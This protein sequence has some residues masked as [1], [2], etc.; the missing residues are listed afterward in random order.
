M[1]PFSR[2]SAA[3]LRSQPS[4]AAKVLED[5]SADSVARYLAA[6]SP[7]TAGQVI[8]HFTPAFAAHCLGALEPVVAGRIFSLLLTDRQ[9]I[10]L[11][12]LEHDRRESLLQT[13]Q[14]DL[15]ASMR[16]L[17]PYP[18]GTAGAVMEAPLA[19]LPEELSVRNA[20]KRV[21]RIQ[22]GMKFYLYATNTGGQL[23]GVLTL[24]EL[25]NTLPSS[26]IRQVMHRHVVSLSS[27]Q[28]IAAIMDSPYWQDYHALPVTDENDVLL[29]VIRQKNL[30]RLQEQALQSRDI[31]DALDSYM[32]VGDLF[33]TTALDLLAVMIDTTTSLIR[34]DSHD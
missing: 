32:A 16:H 7:M 2:L 18:E 30:R 20:I 31:G 34:R 21:K 26:I 10:V 5:Y 12:Q 28:S 9:I 19:S 24:H 25:I 22:N 8:G 4:T 27:L 29:G 14:P 23:T 17:L 1:N 6:T 11:R 3:A 15:A 33:C 13:L